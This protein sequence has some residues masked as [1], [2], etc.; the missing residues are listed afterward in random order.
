MPKGAET[1]AVLRIVVR[2]G[3]SRDMADLLLA[4]LRSVIAELEANPPARPQQ[5]AGRFHH[6]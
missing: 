4:D 3:V 1:I 2:E 6:G 5:A